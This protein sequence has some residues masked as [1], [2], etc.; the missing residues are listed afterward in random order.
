M[1]KIFLII[2]VTLFFCNSVFADWEKFG[3]VKKGGEYFVEK[4]TIIKESG[5][6]YFWKMIDSP[7][8]F[9]DT[10]FYSVKVYIKGDCKV[11]KIKT[12]TFVFYTGKKGTGESEQ[13]ESVNKNWK[14]PTPESI[15]YSILKK[16]C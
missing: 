3:D 11:K 4:D 15:N 8:P 13:Q 6:I 10:N 7:K 16:L 1:K 9:L 12:L 2:S 14:Y 5:Y